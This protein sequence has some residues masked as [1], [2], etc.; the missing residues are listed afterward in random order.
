MALEVYKHFQEKDLSA[1]GS[2]PLTSL[3][4]KS[5]EF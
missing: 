3:R 4:I 1:L 5:Y 2:K